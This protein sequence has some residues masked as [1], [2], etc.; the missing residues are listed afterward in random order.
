MLVRVTV[1]ATLGA[2]A[3]DGRAVLHGLPTTQGLTLDTHRRWVYVHQAHHCD[4]ETVICGQERMKRG[5][6]GRRQDHVVLMRRRL[7]RSDRHKLSSY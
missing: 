7:Q 4:D 6:I 1:S 2:G 5:P 3:F